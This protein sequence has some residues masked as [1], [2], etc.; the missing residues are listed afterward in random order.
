[1]STERK[2]EEIAATL[3]DVTLELDEIAA[4][5]PSGDV[6]PL[7][8]AKSKVEKATDAVEESLRGENHT[9]E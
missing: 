5:T 9:D 4:D 8:R 6:R 3:D 1:M 2:L 7:E